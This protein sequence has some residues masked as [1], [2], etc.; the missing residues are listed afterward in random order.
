VEDPRTDIDNAIATFVGVNVP[1]MN[2]EK[3]ARKKAIALAEIY[4][5]CLIPKLNFETYD[6]ATS[7][8]GK[9][10]SRS[11]CSKRL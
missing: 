7:A 2:M 8:C 9:L 3:K 11:R 4:Q 1:K 6:Q 10:H 5:S